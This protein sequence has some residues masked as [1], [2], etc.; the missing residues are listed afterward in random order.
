MERRPEFHTLLVPPASLF[1]L[2]IIQG[3]CEWVI[4]IKRPV[5]L[6]YDHDYSFNKQS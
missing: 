6:R 2:G 3:S 1:D 4:K 5:D